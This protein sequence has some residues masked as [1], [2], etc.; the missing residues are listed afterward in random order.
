MIKVGV[1]GIGMMGAVHL[2]AYGKCPDVEVVAVADMDPDRRSG[3]SSAQGNIEGQ[4]QGGFDFS[5]VRQYA[6]A[7]ELIAAPDVDV[8]D[9]C[10][11][12]PAHLKFG[13]QALRAGKHVFIEK[14]LSR[15]YSEA[16]ELA[17]A[18]DEAEGLAFCAMCMRFWPGWDWL[19]NVVEEK[20][21]GAVLS[22]T[23]RRIT[24]FPGGPFYSDGKASGGALLDLHIHDVDFI[25][26]L[27]GTPKSVSSHGYSKPT[28]HCDHVLTNYHY[29]DIPIVTAEGGWSMVPGFGFEMEYI[30]N[31]DN[32]TAV[33]R[34][35]DAP[36][37]TLVTE[38]GGK[39]TIPLAEG[40]GYEIELKHFVDCI[41]RGVPSDRI[42]F[43]DAAEAIRIVE[44]EQ[45]SM[46]KKSVV[47]L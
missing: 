34:L 40:L 8:V 17:D 14:P 30:V 29:D 19:K 15:T 41:Q 18:A 22:A 47:S 9:I 38:E 12:T 1:V 36:S 37:L 13:K 20:T 7:S 43:R 10:L 3:K 39:T 42:T 45:E 5:T 31:F 2:E 33:Y 35:S 44:A 46:S 28:T 21:Y 4:K 26:Y 23:F 25:R 6:D 32:A 11:P 27:F 24:Q 16:L